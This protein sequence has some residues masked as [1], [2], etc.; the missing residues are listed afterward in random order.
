MTKHKIAIPLLIILVALAVRL[1]LLCFDDGTIPVGGDSQAYLAIAESLREGNGFSLNGK[2]PTSTRMP[3]YPLFLAGILTSPGAGVRT[4]QILQIIIDSL[5]CLLIYFLARLL[6][7]KSQGALCGLLLALYVP[8]AFWS[9]AV[10]TETL[11]TFFVVTSLLLLAI[12]QSNSWFSGA[13]G[14]VI[15]IATLVRPNGVVVAAFLLLWIWYRYDRP[16]SLRH[17]A[18]FLLLMILVLSPWVVRNGIV[19]HRFIPTASTTGI[20]FYNSYFIPEKGLGFNEIRNEHDQYFSITNEADRSR[21]LTHV[22]AQHI[23]HHPWRALELIPMKLGLLG[24]PFDMKW[25]HQ[26]FPFRYNIFWGLTASL[27]VLAVIAQTS[28]VRHRLSLVIFTLGAPLLTS[29]IFYG[30]PRMRAPFDPFIVVLAAVGAF[31]VWRNR[32]RWLWLGTI[33]ALNSLILLLG[34][35]PYISDYFKI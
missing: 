1:A 10:L 16:E 22:T 35:S 3:L 9:L 26:E 18:A 33:V 24:Y 17:L 4:I 29:I 13:A 2:D 32:R 25:I 12:N 6:L 14:F 19:F 15:G 31:W 11:F 20:T 7:D 23:K 21:Y 28:Y 34:E 5:T 30:S 27:A 8:M